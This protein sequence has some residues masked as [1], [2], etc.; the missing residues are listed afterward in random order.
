[1]KL[2]EIDAKSFDEI[3]KLEPLVTIF[4]SSY[5]AKYKTA[6]N[7]KSQVL[8]LNYLNDKGI[9][10]GLA[11]FLLKKV[12]LFKYEAYSPFGFLFNY[13]DKKLLQDFCKDLIAY[14][15]K[16]K[17][18]D[19]IIEPFIYYHNKRYNN[20]PIIEALHE[21]GFNKTANSFVYHNKLENNDD[22]KAVFDT[23]RFTYDDYSQFTVFANNPDYDL[24]YKN[25][26]PYSKLLAVR[27]NVSKSRRMI[28]DII[29]DLRLK[30]DNDY[31]ENREK[32]ISENK[33]L[34]Q[35]LND[36]HEDPLLC[37]V[38]LVDYGKRLF[39]IINICEEDDPFGAR[40]AMANVI[41]EEARS[42][43][44]HYYDSL[45]NTDNADEIELIGEFTCSR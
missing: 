44:Y 9:S 42:L 15:R 20:E 8:Y 27:L 26:Y 10:C 29:S 1:M 21:V 32:L 6:T 13:Y 41:K 31:D 11:M 12:S 39:E 37:G 17:V 33:V 34:L 3:A 28:N 35:K 43:G 18:D 36:Y 7:N 2:Q 23:V 25:L 30:Q 4:Q 40:K 14:L 22:L 45:K 19:I 38:C 24:L 16:K 5:W